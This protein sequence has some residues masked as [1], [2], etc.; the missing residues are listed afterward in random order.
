V[1]V[2]ARGSGVEEA[3]RCFAAAIV[4]PDGDPRA[5]DL[6]LRGAHP[7]V[8]EIDPP[9]NQI[10]LADAQQLIDE[11]FRSPVEGARKVIV[12]F[13]A[14]RLNDQAANKLLKTLEEPPPTAV[15]VLVTAGADQLLA[16][17]RS[18]CQR[19]DFAFLTHRAV[20]DALAAAGVGPE[21]AELL[22]RLAGGRIDRARALDARLAPVREAFVDATA[23]LDG[24]GGA[25]ARQSERLQESVRAAVADLEAAQAAET[26]ALA[27]ELD[28][29][30]YPERTRR[31]QLR[32]LDEHHKR[33]H[34]HARAEALIEGI[35][36]LESVYRDTLA[37]GVGALNA[38]RARVVVAA[39]D[40]TAALDACR[41]ARQALIEHNPNEGL[42]LER[43]LWHLPPPARAASR[44]K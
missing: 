13:D 41:A 42:M 20:V 31:A 44:R 3:A 22:A 34:R 23:T 40:A 36:A 1:L 17:I 15:I 28:A 43:L 30:G 12:V 10:R 6:A 27:A 19:V 16:T 11:A 24:T 25:V 7:D 38:D 8:V 5:A 9:A 26:E 21:R 4:A 14:E 39:R 35:T 37:D 18:R 2:G 33:V 32:R 29:A